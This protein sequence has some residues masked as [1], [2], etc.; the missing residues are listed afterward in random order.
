[1]TRLTPHPC[2]RVVYDRRFNRDR[3]A[4]FPHD[5]HDLVTAYRHAH[6][7]P[8]RRDR[9]CRCAGTG[10]GPRGRNASVC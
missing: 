3:S 5:R 6:L 1:R 7:I 2:A 4:H 10:R 8:D 9:T